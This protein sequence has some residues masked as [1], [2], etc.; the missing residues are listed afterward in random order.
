MKPV[1]SKTGKEGRNKGGKQGRGER[2]GGGW[3]WRQ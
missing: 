2:R 3:L 1:E